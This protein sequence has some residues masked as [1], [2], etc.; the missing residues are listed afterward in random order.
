MP[1]LKHGEFKIRSLTDGTLYK[2]RV[3]RSDGNPFLAFGKST[4]VWESR[5]SMDAQSA[6]GQAV[7]AI[8][9]GKIKSKPSQ[10]E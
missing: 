5:Q 2:A 1:S 10:A 6:I 4:D 7:Y 8:D 3:Q 9:T